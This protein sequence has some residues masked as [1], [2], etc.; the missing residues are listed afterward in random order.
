MTYSVDTN[1]IKKAM[2]DCDI[3]TIGELAERAEINRNTAAKV[4]N[5]EIR[6]STAVME[7]LMIAL[8]IDPSKAGAIFFAPNLRNT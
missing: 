1:A 8:K 5:G 6:P 3:N 7:R 4:V 2:I